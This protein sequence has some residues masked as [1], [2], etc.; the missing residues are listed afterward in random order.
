MNDA[1]V[2]T[3][4]SMYTPQEFYN[5][6][7]GVSSDSGYWDANFTANPDNTSIIFP[8]A[9][10]NPLNFLEYYFGV[11]DLSKFGNPS[12]VRYGSYSMD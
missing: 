11:Q 2:Q 4:T 9:D 7:P 12:P 10:T 3:S 1:N 8:Q 6:L 5:N